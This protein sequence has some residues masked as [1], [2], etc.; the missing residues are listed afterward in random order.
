M[1]RR[2]HLAMSGDIFGHQNLGEKA[3]TGYCVGAKDVAKHLTIHGFHN[4]EL[5]VQNVSCTNGEKLCC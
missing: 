2:E 4:K 1:S 3:A 5:S